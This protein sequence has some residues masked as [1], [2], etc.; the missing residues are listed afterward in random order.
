MFGNIKIDIC[1]GKKTLK[2]SK[3]TWKW[4]RSYTLVSFCLLILIIPLCVSVSVFARRH[5]NVCVWCRLRILGKSESCDI[6]EWSF[7][8]IK[9]EWRGLIF[10]IVWK[11]SSLSDELHLPVSALRALAKRVW[12]NIW[13]LLDFRNY[14]S[15]LITYWDDRWG[16]DTHIIL[17]ALY[18]YYSF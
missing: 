3:Y 8:R 13:R 9:E 14:K 2:F 5:A 1:L 10:M 11:P 18:C 16:S 6:L 4:L 15:G 7:W 12:L 17:P